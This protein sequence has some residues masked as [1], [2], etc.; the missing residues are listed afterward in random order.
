MDKKRRDFMKK[1]AY[2]APMLIALGSLAKPE[3][4]EAADGDLRSN[5]PPPPPGES[6]TSSWNKN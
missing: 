5:L 2:K 4:A 1:A 6:Q 3:K